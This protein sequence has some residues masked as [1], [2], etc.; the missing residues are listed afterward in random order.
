MI[1]RLIDLGLL[2]FDKAY[3]AQKHILSRLKK[4]RD[5]HYLILLEHEPVFTLGRLGR[6]EN[7]ITEKSGRSYSDVPVVRT[8]RG[9]DITFHGP[10]Q[11]VAYPVFDLTRLYKDIHKFLRA[12][13]TVIISTLSDYGVRAYALDGR[14]GC[15]TGSGKIASI[16][17][18]ASSWITYHGLAL[19]ANVKLKYFEMINP[20]GFNDIRMTSMKEILNREVDIAELKDRL[21]LNFSDVF[22]LEVQEFSFFKDQSICK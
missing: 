20:C 17:V 11:V 9:G 12:L 2:S 1:C 19:N 21:V 10:G 8:D 15:W 7:L 6:E 14:T 13:E 16:G 18:G 22:S 5:G 4:Q 3:S